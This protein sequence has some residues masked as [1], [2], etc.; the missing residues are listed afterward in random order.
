[1]IN[2][3]YNIYSPLNT[4]FSPLGDKRS[5]Q[6]HGIPWISPLQFAGTPI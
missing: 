3:K 5:A 4:L 2:D 6:A 1:M